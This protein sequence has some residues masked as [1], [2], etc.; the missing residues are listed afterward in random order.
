MMFLSRVLSFVTAVGLVLLA[1]DAR[2]Q[3]TTSAI[4]G[5][6]R[7]ASGAALAGVHVTARHAGTGLARTATTDVHGRYMLAALPLGAFEVRAER[8][9]FRPLLRREVSLP[10]GEAV[11]L[12]LRL[13]LGAM[14]QEV[15]VT[16]ET[17]RVRTDSG[18]LSYLVSERTIQTLPLNGRNYTDLALLQ[19]GVVAYPH[20]DGGSVVAH[21][22]GMSINGQDP[23]ANVYLLDG[24]LQNDFTNAPASSAAG[25][26]L[27]TETIQEFRVE[28]NAYGAEFGRSS[29]GQIHVVTKSGSN[30]WKG[31]AYEFHRNEAFDARNFFDG[32][33]KPE[34]S[35]NQFG[36]TLGGP[37]KKDGTFFFVGYEGL[38]ENLGRTISTVVPD[39]AVRARAVDPAVRPY[40]DAFPRPNGE[41]LGGGLAAYRFGFD[42]LLDQDFFQ[43]RLDQILGTRDH[44]F[45]RYTVDDAEQVLPTDFPQ[46]PRTF[47][48][49]NHFATA[50]LRHAAS[51][52]ML[53]TLRAG[54]SR[55]HVRQEVQANL[56][57]PLSPFVP[58]RA[59][60]G[61]IDIGGIPR[62]GPQT[63]AN[64][65][66]AQSVY[67]LEYGLTR[68]QGRH[69]LKAG[70]LAERY[71]ADL[72]NP[73][74]S[75][76]IFAFANV[77]A[78]LANRP[79]RFVGLTPE[80][81]LE[82][83]WR[84]TL[85]AGY[86]QDDFRVAPRLT[87]NAGLRYEFAT[88][89]KDIGGR[90]STLVNRTDPEP[91]VGQLYQNP[92]GRNVSPR[93]G[94]AWDLFGNGRTSLRGGY[95]LYFNTNNQQNL[96]VTITN[97]PATPR[98]IIPNPTFPVPP[99]E[100][101]IGNTIRPVQ[102][103]LQTPRVHVWNVN[104]QRD[105]GWQT[106]VTAGYAGA[107]GKHL[108]RSG[109]VN[110]PTPQT[111]ADGSLFF[112]AGSPRPNPAF[113]T[114][115]QKTSDGDS[116]Y[117]ALVVEVRR[118]AAR[119]LSFQSSYTFSRNIDTTQASTFFSDATNG[120]TSA[121]PDFGDL[122]YNRGLADYHAKH[123]WIFNLSYELPFARDAAGLRR[124]LIG[125]WQ[126]AL[127][128]QMRSGPPLTLFVQS[129]RSRSLWSPSIGPGLGL[130][131]PS[132]APGRTAEDAVLGRP[133][134]WFDPTAFMLPAA[135]T[136]GNLGRGA[137]TGPDL[138]VLDVALIKHVPW[139]RGSRDGRIELRLEAFN[140]LNR[141]NLGIP[142]LQAFA[143][144]A[145]GEA[146]LASLGRIRNTVT[147]ARQVQLGVRVAF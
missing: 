110:V 140:V 25:T 20:R 41:T 119:G 68:T 61:N 62:F 7:D 49:R 31:S 123:N 23:R 109:D 57:E 64:V 146:P 75:L 14:D 145:D 4:T 124:A 115:E 80:S 13:E 63:S 42:Q 120:T 59:S 92:T 142:S 87:L 125:G 6:V 114:I 84:F 73:T 85:L 2:A 52:A 28:V 100:R 116:W 39:D 15:T 106:A 136:L 134:Q 10:V 128:G 45:L 71:V 79:L 90:D 97:P 17:P 147:S 58:T 83:K 76:G 78:F 40:L 130:D 12:D 21:G 96:I 18:E 91:L 86:L 35:R 24:T 141:A 47:A 94:F 34:F 19:P 8:E 103:D 32:D 65:S 30:E 29:G 16:A 26:T 112:P 72:F 132:L 3:S 74:F 70:V 135:G 118:T 139:S 105:L 48:S 143:G 117:N 77:D 121:F 46:F 36:V 108:L 111:R 82:R 1:T 56:E 89:P 60:L 53:H 43:A 102:W 5:L 95:G 55:T 99:F 104:L 144:A 126:V 54:F 137:L 37:L 81:D 33:D 50:E 27:G 88:L 93:V 51:D 131:R 11:T 138:Q 107:R 122:Q 69:L 44:L 67:S 9:G 133:E 127:I 129:N 113:T 38:R 98:I 22:M 101:G 66:L